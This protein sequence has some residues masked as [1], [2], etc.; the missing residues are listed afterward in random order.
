MIVKYYLLVFVFLSSSV[1]AGFCDDSGSKQTI[2]RIQIFNHNAYIL[3]DPGL[4]DQA[5]AAECTI[6]NEVV[7]QLAD[8]DSKEIYSLLMAAML[9]DKKAAMTY[10]GG[11]SVHGYKGGSNT[12]PVVTSVSVAQ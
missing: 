12:L 3:L 6:K 4:K 10:C 2:K 5:D 11:C 8:E 9:A 7:L 1:S